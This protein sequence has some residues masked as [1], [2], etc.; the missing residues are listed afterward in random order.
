MRIVYLHQYFRTP[1]MS[2]GT[3]SY[4]FARRLVQRGH[5]VHVVTS[6]TDSVPDV[7]PTWR[8]TV[9]AGVVVHWAAVPYRNAMS[10]RARI[11]AFGQFARLAA[12]RAASLEQDVIFAT[13]TPLTIAIP[14]VY[15]ARRRRVPMVLEVRDLWPEVPIALGAL[16]SPLL[17]RA[18]TTLEVWAYRNAAHVVA[19]S[20][21]MA[22]GVRARCPGATVTVVPNGCDR[23]LFADADTAGRALRD[24][25]PWLGGRPLILYAGTLGLVND[26]GYLVRMAATLRRDHPDVRVALVGQGA[27]AAHVRAL[28]VESGVLGRN[29]FLLDQVSKAEVVAFFAACDLAVSTVRDEPALH[30]NSANKVFDGWAAGRPVAVNHEGWIA[31]VLRRSGAGLV[32]PAG[33]PAAAATL[34]GA[35]VTDPARTAAARAAARVVAATEFDRDLLF[36]RFEQVLQ[37]AARQRRTIDPKVRQSPQEAANR[38]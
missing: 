15:S 34:V 8:T 35:F 7:G 38:S 4:E 20:P 10:F 30:A 3:R 29:L 2:G 6:D 9:E 25:T 37:E 22:A 14:A 31:D 16:R 12:A 27:E 5:E 11:S 13:S 1:Q 36:E 33:D 26:V 19:L 17:R 28:A 21:G 18:A 24:R 32:L 23:H